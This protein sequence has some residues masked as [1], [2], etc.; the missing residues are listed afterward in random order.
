MY[1]IRTPFVFQKLFSK[2]IWNLPNR[3]S[4]IYLTFDDGPNPETTY[5]ILEQLEKYNAKATFFCL[6][7]NAEKYPDLI[8][9]IIEAG[10]TIANHGYEH[11]NGW[12]ISSE[13]YQQNI[14]KGKEVL[15]TLTE[16]E[17]KLFRPPY[18]KFKISHH[19]HFQSKMIL[20]S[21]MPG[22]FDATI[23][24]PQCF[25]NISTKIKQGDI[26]CLHDSTQAQNHLQYCLP[27]WLEFIYNKGL[28]S[29]NIIL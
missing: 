5:W 8:K 12:K 28:K 17:V 10:H 27:N 18:G 29:E 19:S 21:L 3:A 22:D 25:K 9:K 2:I 11:L 20:W 26:I 23:S 13:K 15:E 16:N 1:F 7:V 24:S 6:G 14:I 4:V